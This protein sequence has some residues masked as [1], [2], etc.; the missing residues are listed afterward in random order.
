[1]EAVGP[2]GSSSPRPPSSAESG[3]ACLQQAGAGGGPRFGA[4]LAKGDLSLA[5]PPRKGRLIILLLSIPLPHAQETKSRDQIRH[6]ELAEE[7]G[8]VR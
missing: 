1:M 6:A 8:Q 3:Q 7:G 2:E 4:E 5:G